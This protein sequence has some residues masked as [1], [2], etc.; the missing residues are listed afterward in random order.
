MNALAP[1]TRIDWFRILED[2]AREG[3]SLYEVAQ[4]TTIPKNTLLGYRNNGIEP[5]HD[6]GDVLLKFWAQVKQADPASA[7]RVPRLP[8]AWNP[9]ERKYRRR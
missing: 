8:S 6:V 4:F 7:P 3:Y 9:S 2:V 5:R 1:T